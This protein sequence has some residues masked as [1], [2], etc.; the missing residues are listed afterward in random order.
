MTSFQIAVP[1]SYFGKLGKHTVS[2]SGDTP[3]QHT[4]PPA[5]LPAQSPAME[6]EAML[7]DLDHLTSLD[8]LIKQ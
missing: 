5:F 7:L 6:L 3:T 1:A 8:D 4:R 2:G